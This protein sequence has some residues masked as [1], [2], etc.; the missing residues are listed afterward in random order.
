MKVKTLLNELQ[1]L[2]DWLLDANVL[3]SCGEIKDLDGLVKV[4]IDGEPNIILDSNTEATEEELCDIFYG[5]AFLL[6]DKDD[7]L[8]FN[9]MDD[10]SDNA[11][12]S[13]GFQP[14]YCSDKFEDYKG[15]E[16]LLG[17]TNLVDK[18]TIYEASESIWKFSSKDH[19]ILTKEELISDIENCG[20]NIHFSD[21]TKK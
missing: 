8:F 6:Y 20:L 17:H 21:W 5:S 2:P 16:V 15:I 13:I 12:I 11:L 9:I 4:A 14:Y 7:K 10:I 19:H 18:Y 3:V 1:K